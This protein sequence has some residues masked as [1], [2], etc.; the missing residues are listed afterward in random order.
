MRTVLTAVGWL[1]TR[2]LVLWLL[3]GPEAWVHGDVSYFR[4]SLDRV[5]VDGLA[6]TLAEY[7]LPAVAVLAVPWALARALDVAGHFGDLMML[8]ALLTDAAFMV[9]LHV[10]GGIRR[11]H[12]TLMWVLAVPLLG[13]T[14]YARFD[15]LPGVLV[16]VTVLLLAAHPRVAAAAAAVAT[17]VKLWPALVLPAL[18]SG[19]RRPRPVATVVLGIGVVLAGG[20]VLAAGWGRL[21]SP[22][23][24]QAARGLQIESVAATPAMLGWWVEPGRW[25]ISYAASRAYEI[26]GPGVGAL[27]VLT[28]VL[29][30]L[31]MGG[32][33]SS[34]WWAWRLRDRLSGIT[35]VWLVLS[36][37][38]GFV[39]TGK[40]LSPQYLL[41]LLPAGAAGL[42][43][44]A[45][46]RRLVRWCAVLL[47]ATGVTQLLFP[48]FY[49]GLTQRADGQVTPAVLL[50]ALR[51]LLV[52]CLL[53]GAWLAT[54]RS[55]AEDLRRGPVA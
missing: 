34:W 24:Y 32:L 33:L 4:A 35:V 38:T 3:Y 16:G 42:A 21:L 52:F 49:A 30:V 51:N 8:G 10:F 7:P 36:A 18:F 47:V 45:G 37:V 17:G 19:V 15:L 5:P 27:L 50:L 13:A 29:T 28:S 12:A 48:G 9:L 39:A 20:T 14:A 55:L 1:L 46:E 11:A 41:W 25:R 43:V 26:T 31:L 6:H 53:V 44:G 40:V 23:S 22:V 2:G 54:Y